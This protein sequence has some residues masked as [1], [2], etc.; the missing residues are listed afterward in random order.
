MCG[1]GSPRSVL[2]GRAPPPF[3]EQPL[4]GHLRTEAVIPEVR[5][6]HGSLPPLCLSVLIVLGCNAV[7]VI[8]ISDRTSY[9]RLG[10][11]LGHSFLEQAY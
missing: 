5:Q 10:V 8:V 4:L 7:Q 1:C 6:Q 3:Q 2:C 9:Q 11:W